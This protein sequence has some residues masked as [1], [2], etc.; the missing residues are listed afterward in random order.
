[1]KFKIYR[2]NEGFCS[3]TYITRNPNNE[4][5]YYC[6]QDNG[7]EQPR[8]ELYRCTK[9]LE[10]DYKVTLK[11]GTKAKELF[12]IP[13]GDSNIEKSCKKWIEDN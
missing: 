6:L 13:K 11:I 8:I 3:I 1:M 7:C 12:E 4:K 9:K 10:P 2:I 5:I